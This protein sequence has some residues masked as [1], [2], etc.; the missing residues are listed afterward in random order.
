M[1]F[2]ACSFVYGV[3]LNAQDINCIQCVCH[4]MSVCQSSKRTPLSPHLAA[5]PSN[6]RSVGS[7][8]R[9]HSGT[10]GQQSQ[11]DQGLRQDVYTFIVYRGD[12]VAGK[13]TKQ[14]PQICRH[15]LQ[16]KTFRLLVLCRNGSTFVEQLP[17]ISTLSVSTEISSKAKG[18]FKPVFTYDTSCHH[19]HLASHYLRRGPAVERETQPASSITIP[20]KASFITKDAN[21]QTRLFLA[22]PASSVELCCNARNYS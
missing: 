19:F 8:Q 1:K 7:A 2:K 10:Q 9:H 12:M 11:T 14:N 22:T 17:W 5:V 15:D 18:Q 16:I 20:P 6:A 13:G 3:F 21:L 4:S